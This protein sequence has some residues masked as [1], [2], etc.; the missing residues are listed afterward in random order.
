MSLKLGVPSKGRLQQDAFDWF[1]AR[2]VVLERTGSAR[3]YAGRV[4]GA[5]GIDLVLLSA[6]EI[7]AELARGRLHL[8][9]TGQDLVR[10]QFPRWEGVVAEVA[11]LGFGRADLVVAA[12]AAWIDVAD[13][14]DL[15]AAAAA[16]REAH[17][18]RLRVAT[19][20]HHLVRDFFR[21]H[22][23]AD[24]QLVGS[25]G[26][27]E[28]AVKNL[29]AEAV[30]DITSTGSTLRDNHLKVLA[31]GLILASQATLFAA[32]AARWTDRDRRALEA[33]AARLGLPPP[34]LPEGPGAPSAAA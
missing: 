5:P 19:K 3:E 12:P 28:A 23:V 13:M 20:Y 34:P 14:A 8:G 18:F 33:M 16:F 22:G 24:Y 32:R 4:R 9:V 2:G 1:A 15:D 25:Q 30:A 10:E 31:D 7:P 21:R 29:T 6:A 11:P 26:A 27:T 17:G